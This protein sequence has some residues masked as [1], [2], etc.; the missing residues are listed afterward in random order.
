MLSSPWNEAL[1]AKVPEV[2]LCAVMHFNKGDRRYSWLP[3]VPSRVPLNT[4]L[5]R[6][7]YSIVRA[8]KESPILESEDGKFH[9]PSELVYVP[10]RFREANG[11]LLL[12]FGSSNAKF[13]SEKYL[14]GHGEL[15]KRLDVVTMSVENFIDELACF[16]DTRQAEFRS[17]PAAWHEQVCRILCSADL[18]SL[19]GKI[20]RLAIVPLIGFD[21]WIAPSGARI[22]FSPSGEEPQIPNGLGVFQVSA[23]IVAE[24][25]GSVARRNLFS[26]LGVKPY[27]S[28]VI[29]RAI[30]STHESPGFKP[31]SLSIEDIVSH[32][33][34]LKRAGEKSSTSKPNLWVASTD[35]SR[36]RTRSVYLDLDSRIDPLGATTVLK[37]YHTQIQFLHERYET[38]L[39]LH[40]DDWAQWL[41]SQLGVALL[42]RLVLETG[43][44]FS[45][46][47]DFR[48]L[49]EADPQTALRLLRDRWGHYKRWIVPSENESQA[50]QAAFAPSRLAVIH[51]LSHMKVPCWG[52][53]T[54]LLGKTFLPRKGVLL[55]LDLRHDD[56][57]G[58]LTPASAVGTQSLL[59]PDPAAKRPTNLP[60]LPIE[61]AERLA[62]QEAGAAS[63]PRRIFDFLDVQDPENPRWN[64]LQ[65]FGVIT[66]LEVTVFLHR[67]RQLKQ[68]ATK[69]SQDE[70]AALYQLIEKRCG[71]QEGV[72]GSLAKVR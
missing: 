27:D 34:F 64:F 43:E 36:C 70:V 56:G 58:T 41:V 11:K 63:H 4:P 54:A 19:L 61:E 28:T 67:L 16:I 21:K 8:L 17:K 39:S 47:N 23:D 51:A 55:G 12:P 31:G 72:E 40:G 68:K 65:E 35:G 9:C 60:D 2:F 15:F 59:D 66:K 69:V 57:D 52:G 38:E 1:L 20:S 32:V 44:K 13:L 14:Y 25:R 62:N 45:I 48:W 10:N 3:F 18:E 29:C 71:E 26:S 42:P 6:I 30:I 22:Y 33:V 53:G 46:S 49:C 5:W 50:R 24:D 7:P 37:P